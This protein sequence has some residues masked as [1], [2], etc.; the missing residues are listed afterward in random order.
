MR[1]SR[2]QR[3]EI[4]LATS[5]RGASKVEKSRRPTA[6]NSGKMFMGKELE[7]GEM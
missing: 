5:W 7:E 4:R 1:E 6:D 2:V 3:S